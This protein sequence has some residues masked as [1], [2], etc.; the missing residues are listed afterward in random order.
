MKRRS[1]KMIYGAL[2]GAM[3]TVL[4][5]LSAS[6]GM[7]NGLIQVRISEALTILPLFTSSAIWGLFAGC[8]ISNILTGCALW[9]IIFG[10]LATLLG[11]MITYYIGKL[12]FKNSYFF[13]PIGPILSNT[14][15]IPVI[16]TYVYGLTEAYYIICLGIFAGEL[17]SAGLLGILLYLGLKRHENV[18]FG[19]EN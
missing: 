6:F 2:V 17:I 3:Y 14:A 5:L 18:I 4:T 12:K 11:A 13:A 19:K 8:I 1:K 9:D 15:I 10:S 16:L 7:A